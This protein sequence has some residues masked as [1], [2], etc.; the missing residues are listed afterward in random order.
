VDAFAAA[1]PDLGAVVAVGP[2]AARLAG[3]VN[4]T[5]TPLVT[6]K[7]W[8]ETGALAS[9]NAA[10][11]TLGAMT[12]PREAAPVSSY[13]G[14]RGQIPRADLPFG[15]LRWNG[16]SGDRGVRAKEDGTPSPDYYKVFM[17]AWAAALA[18][19]PLSDSEAA[20]VAK[21]PHG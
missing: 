15:A 7:A 18:P 6:M 1:S 2:A 20:A 3:H 13:D 4:A 11:D 9:W 10:L 8:R 19:A 5:G 16:T 17:P 12:F 14:S 21:I